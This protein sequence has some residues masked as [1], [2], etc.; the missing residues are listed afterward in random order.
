MKRAQD[1]LKRGFV[2]KLWVRINRDAAT[3]VA[4]RHAVICVQFDLDAVGMACNGLVHR[5]VEDFG[6]HVVQGALVRA[7]NIHT[8]AF[9]NGLETLEHFDAV[10][11]IV[12]GLGAGQKIIGHGTAS[13]IRV[14]PHYDTPWASGEVRLVHLDS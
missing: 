14:W 6:D 2:G 10:C 9:A 12:I 8:G 4:D 5:V 1:H 13:F 11:V 3:V 7:A